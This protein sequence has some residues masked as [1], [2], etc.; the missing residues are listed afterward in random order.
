MSLEEVMLASLRFVANRGGLRLIAVIGLLTVNGF[1]I[2]EP[3][4][5]N[6]SCYG[7]YGGPDNIAFCALTE[8]GPSWACCQDGE[9]GCDAC[10]YDAMGQVATCDTYCEPTIEG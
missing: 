10:C 5:A 9:G 3:S 6:S 8:S 7:C 1:L 2:P 4:Q